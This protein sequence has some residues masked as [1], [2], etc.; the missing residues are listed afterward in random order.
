MA[1]DVNPYNPNELSNPH[2]LPASEE[3]LLLDNKVGQVINSSSHAV[4]AKDLVID[5]ARNILMSVAFAS[6]RQSSQLMQRQTALSSDNVLDGFLNEDVLLEESQIDTLTA[7]TRDLL[8]KL[9]AGEFAPINRGNKEPVKMKVPTTG[10]EATAVKDI[11]AIR[12][13]DSDDDEI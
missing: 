4:F 13:D 1:G 11:E 2:I 12:S 5:I 6:S 9:A 8:H 3:G 10:E 7:S